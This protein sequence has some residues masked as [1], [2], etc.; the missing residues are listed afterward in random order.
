MVSGVMYTIYD[1]T[2][3]AIMMLRMIS[4]NPVKHF[5]TIK[6]RTST[7]VCVCIL[8]VCLHLQYFRAGH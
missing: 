8:S 6:L 4:M 2:K 1:T 5:S 7:N 3:F